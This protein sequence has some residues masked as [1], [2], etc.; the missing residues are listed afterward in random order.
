MG[1]RPK[2]SRFLKQS[3]WISMLNSFYGI[4]YLI[5]ASRTTVLKTVSPGAKIK[6]QSIYPVIGIF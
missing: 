2:D 6:E 4:D 5:F 1:I 3:T